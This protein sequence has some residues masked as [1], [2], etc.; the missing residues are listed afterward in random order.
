M[1]DL[2]NI[3]SNLGGKTK[4]MKYHLYMTKM[5]PDRV[6]GWINLGVYYQDSGNLDEALKCYDKAKELVA[7]L[8]ASI[9]HNRGN[10]LFGKGRFKEAISNFDD[11]LKLRPNNVAT[12]YAKAD[13]LK[14]MRDISCRVE[15]IDTNM[16]MP[17][18]LNKPLTS[19]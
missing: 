1:N 2:A 9:W 11:S 6:E 8:M 19:T 10:I 17:I 12:L 5:H 15:Q 18:L 13:A 7:P 3:W 4:A 16:L 14:K